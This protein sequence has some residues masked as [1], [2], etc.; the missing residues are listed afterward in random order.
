MK[1]HELFRQDDREEPTIELFRRYLDEMMSAKHR[2]V[3]LSS[4]ADN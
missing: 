1:L 3:S 4:W 2:P